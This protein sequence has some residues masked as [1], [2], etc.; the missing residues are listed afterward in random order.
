MFK[1]KNKHYE[2]EL[3]YILLINEI[4]CYKTDLFS[5]KIIKPRF[6]HLDTMQN[7]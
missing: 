6:K 3:L 5:Y 2:H 1:L 4:I 7:I